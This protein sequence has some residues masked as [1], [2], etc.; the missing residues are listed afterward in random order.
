VS[1]RLFPPYGPGDHERR[2]I[3]YVIRS[4]YEGKIPDLTTGRQKW[5][6]VYIE[7]VVNAFLSVLKAFPLKKH[8]DLINIGTGNPVSVRDI[9]IM[10]MEMMDR[11]SELPWGSVPHRKNEVWFNSAD[12]KKSREIL[13]W[14]P[15]TDIREGMQKTIAWF[16]KKR[17]AGA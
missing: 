8:Y 13:G 10:I 17:D 3:P 6:F 9:V 16:T 2:L 12:I 14:E 11:Q 1:L 5:D 7:D 15:A 4:F